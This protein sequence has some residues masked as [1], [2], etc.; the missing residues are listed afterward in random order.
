MSGTSLKLLEH[1][2][3]EEM[4][5]VNDSKLSLN[6]LALTAFNCVNFLLEEVK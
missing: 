6:S 1:N 2:E 3:K 5:H 4:I